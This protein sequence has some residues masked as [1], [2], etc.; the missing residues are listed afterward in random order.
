M[1]ELREM[2]NL[3]GTRPINDPSDFQGLGNVL[4]GKIRWA[5]TSAKYFIMKHLQPCIKITTY[6]RLAT[7]PPIVP[8]ISN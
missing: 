4:K 2:I 3:P 1:K 8:Y 7:S 6:M 5:K